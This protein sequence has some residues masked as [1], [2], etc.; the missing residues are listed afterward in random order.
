MKPIQYKSIIQLSIIL[1]I[2]LGC[3]KSS[4]SQEASTETIETDS[5]IS[6][7]FV[8]NG[9]G[10]IP[11]DGGYWIMNLAY[12]NAKGDTLFSSANQ[13]GPMP[14]NYVA[15]NFKKNASIEECFSLIGEGDS[16]VFYINADS[17]YKNSAGG[18]TPPDLVGTNIKL[19]IGIEKVFTT[20]EFVAYTEELKNNQIAREKTVIEEYLSE[21][22]ITAEVTEEGLY[23]EIIQAGNGEKPQVGQNVKV[24]YTGY[25][26]DG[27]VFDTSIE[28]TAKEAGIYTPGR[29]YN[30][31]E[32]LLGQGR[33][34]KGWDIGIGLLG[35]G[36]K[37]K[38][39]IPSPL[40]YGNRSTGALIKANS[41]LV[42]TV[43][44]VEI[45]Q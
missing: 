2:A 33:V 3:S 1:I 11:P 6:Y 28:E 24:N 18:P 36:G 43:E 45:G 4:N 35:V 14:M 8:N 21:N 39:V 15:A 17:L 32:F 40:A 41:T 20:E 34:I 7:Q 30:P 31:I 29:P 38:L 26:L 12:Y 37:A 42:F 5:G 23:Y 25:L 27:T 22:G 10:D 44:L 16:A 19:S 13:G 9:S